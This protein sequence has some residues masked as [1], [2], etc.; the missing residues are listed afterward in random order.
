[1][2]LMPR[3]ESRTVSQSCRKENGN[4]FELVEE[5]TINQGLQ[6]RRSFLVSSE[7]P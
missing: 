5:K 4:S 3:S 6:S 2:C 1:M 7:D